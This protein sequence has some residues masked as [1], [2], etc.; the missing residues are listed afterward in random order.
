MYKVK[1]KDLREAARI[2]Y[3]FMVDA[4][5][6]R[7]ECSIW[8]DLNTPTTI[9]NMGKRFMAEEEFCQLIESS[10]F[11]MVACVGSTDETDK[12]RAVLAMMPGMKYMKLRTKISPGA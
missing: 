6:T 10:R 11:E 8:K 2:M 4:D 5:L 12:R 7:P 3:C 1:F 9:T